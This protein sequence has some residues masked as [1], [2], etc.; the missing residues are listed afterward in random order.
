MAAAEADI[1]V[2]GNGVIGSS[3]AFELRRRG[4]QVL[5]VGE[6]SRPYAASM[7]AGAMLGCFGEVTTSLLASPSGRAKLATD[8]RARGEWP[9]W[10]VDLS[11][12]SGM[13]DKLV[14]TDG[15]VVLLN[16]IGTAAVDSENFKAIESA[17]LEYAEHFE[18]VDPEDL[19][20]FSPD[21]LARSLRAIFIPGERAVDAHR[22]LEKL[23]KGFQNIGGQTVD[24]A[25]RD[26]EVRNGR[27][28]GVR[29]ANNEVLRSSHV[30][31]AAG[32]QSLTL[33]NQIE[34]VRKRIPPM[35]SGYGVSALLEV[36]DRTTPRSVLR[37]PNRAFACGIHC[38]PRSAEVLY[39]G[40]TNVLTEH[41]RKFATVRDLQ[42]LLECAVDQ[43]HSRLPEAGVRAV[44]VGNRPVPADGFPLIGATGVDGLTL[45]TGT[46]R[47]GLHQSPLIARHIATLIDGTGAVVDELS[48]FT[49]QRRPLSAGS[50]KEIIDTVVEHLMAS[51]Y[52]Q[53]WRVAPEW[54]QRLRG[55]IRRHY[56]DLVEHLHP[57]FT[58]PAEFIPKINDSIR[59]SITTYYKSWQ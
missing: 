43:L 44:Q 36:N 14:T 58:P 23:R 13:G 37:T 49:P 52:E 21:E 27:A 17:L 45:A 24:D 19:D 20:W 39:V 5:L 55:F 57:D 50:R 40:G 10:D 53:R 29:L 8:Y 3:I 42:F 4:H 35:V 31:V 38:V 51:G 59:D 1:I 48:T 41:P 33:F 16:T 7:A 9:Q 12:A 15:T 47:D 18:F 25:V 54:P 32:A 22:L 26:I 11:V 2:V 28:V 30:V 6:R 46:Y 34:D 56:S